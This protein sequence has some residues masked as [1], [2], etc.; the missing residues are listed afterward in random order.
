MRATLIVLL[1]LPLLA[2]YCQGGGF[3]GFGWSGSRGV[4]GSIGPGPPAPP[5]R[6]MLPPP[7]PPPE[8]TEP[9]GVPEELLGPPT[10]I[11]WGDNPEP[12]T[13]APPPTEEPYE[14][15]V[16]PPSPVLVKPAPI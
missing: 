8:A 13:A 9:V 16:S 6:V 10:D 1:A 14:V 12:P 2:F 15:P 7:G 4:G 3:T 5:P 11:D